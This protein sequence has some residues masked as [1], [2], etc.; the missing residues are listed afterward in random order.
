[1]SFRSMRPGKTA[2]TP[3][4]TPAVSDAA[5]TAVEL[6]KQAAALEAAV[7]TVDAEVMPP[8][9]APPVRAVAT[10]TPASGG[11]SS[12]LASMGMA[13]AKAAG[14]RALST[15]AGASGFSTMYPCVKLTGGS[16]GGTFAPHSSTPPEYLPRLPQGLVAIQGVF[17]SYRYLAASWPVAY[18]DREDGTK[19]VFMAIIPNDAP[20]DIELLT[21]A[22]KKYNYTPKTNR[23]KFDLADSG[24]GH[25]SP[26]LEILMFVPAI[27][28][29]MML[30]VSG[31]GNVE[32]TNASIEKHIDPETQT[33]NPFPCTVRIVTEST[34][35]S[36][37]QKPWKQH[38]LDFNGEPNAVGAKLAADFA[39]WLADA[40]SDPETVAEFQKWVKGGDGSQLDDK[41]R[42][43]LRKGKVL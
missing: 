6:R 31:Y 25:I 29:L 43:M 34:P 40:K 17:L 27:G 19:P 9:T 39:G 4:S 14:V 32:G 2:A 7:P 30:T 13:P 24:V 16:G 22:A 5:A 3:P 37:G 8:T 38:R 35:G 41:Q 11:L 23:K 10:A 42:D 12:M 21:A 28:E 18:D 33:I 20:A 36:A 1:M 15:V 26:T